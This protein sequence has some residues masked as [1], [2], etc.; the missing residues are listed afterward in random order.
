MAHGHHVHCKWH[1]FGIIYF[2][3]CPEPPVCTSD[4]GSFPVW[5][6]GSIIH[7]TVLLGAGRYTLH[8]MC[9]H[10]F[11]FGQVLP[12][13]VINTLWCPGTISTSSRHMWVLVG[14]SALGDHWY[15]F[16]A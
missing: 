9:R 10:R 3:S 13:W 15:M 7:F 4:V 6:G 5:S 11:L 16:P 8:V 2:K 1:A 14:P 12:L